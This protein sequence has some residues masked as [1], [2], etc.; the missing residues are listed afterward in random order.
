MAPKATVLREGQDLPVLWSL[1]DAV[2][3]LVTLAFPRNKMKAGLP[4]ILLPGLGSLHTVEGPRG[5]FLPSLKPCCCQQWAQQLYCGET[6][7]KLSHGLCHFLRNQ[8]ENKK[9]EKKNP[10]KKKA[11]RR[12]SRGLESLTVTKDHHHHTAPTGTDYRRALKFKACRRNGPC[13]HHAPTA[14]AK[15]SICQ[16]PHREPSH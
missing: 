7:T 8:L 1:W 14:M 10:R 5:L 11:T 4:L 16:I 9:G 2:Q 6:G 3:G 13:P 12:E 15:V